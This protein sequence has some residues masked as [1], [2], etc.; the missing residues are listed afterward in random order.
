[1]SSNQGSVVISYEV[2]T[3][4]DGNIMPITLIQKV[5]S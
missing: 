2:D 5:I 4:S 1:M 3:G